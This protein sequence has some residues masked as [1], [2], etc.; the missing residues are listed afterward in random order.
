MELTFGLF[1][2]QYDKTHKGAAYKTMVG[3]VLGKDVEVRDVTGFATLKV[4]NLDDI[5]Y[6]GRRFVSALRQ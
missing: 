3:E 5:M 4:R 2:L 1:E 6:R